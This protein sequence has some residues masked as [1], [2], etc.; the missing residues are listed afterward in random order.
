VYPVFEDTQYVGSN[1]PI[2]YICLNTKTH[3]KYDYR[4]SKMNGCTLIP[5]KLVNEVQLCKIYG[6]NIIWQQWF[7]K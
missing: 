1:V 5:S 4:T 3:F 6:M 7:W 2:L